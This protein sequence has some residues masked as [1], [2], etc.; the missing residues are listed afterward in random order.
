MKCSKCGAELEEGAVFCGSCGAKVEAEQTVEEPIEAVQEE[1]SA[2]E[3]A[4]DTQAN[5]EGASTATYAQQ[6]E[7]ERKA[8][9]SV[10][11]VFT[12][13]DSE[14]EPV[15]LGIWVCRNLI[16]FIPFVGGLAYI[17]MLFVWAF[18][19]KYNSTSRNWARAE[20]I[21]KAVGIVIAIV[22]ISMIVI[23]LSAIDFDEMVNDMMRNQ[24]YHG[25]QYYY[26]P[27]N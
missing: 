9:P 21:F 19:K 2:P 15:S 12:Q 17:I 26:Y 24:H 5:G 20:L 13:N 14:G 6:P 4:A 18:D 16:R 8:A 23:F 27:F 10:S 7:P 25:N 3:D 1:I 11:A 22:I